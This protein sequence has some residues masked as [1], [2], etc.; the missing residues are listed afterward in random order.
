M[1]PESSHAPNIPVSRATND[2]D[3]RVRQ[4]HADWIRAFLAAN[5]LSML[6]GIA[7]PLVTRPV[8][9]YDI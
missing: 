5:G 1:T 8:G 2:R 9:E 7:L 3:E 4:M 6:I